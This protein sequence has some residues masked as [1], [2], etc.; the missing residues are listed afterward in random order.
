MSPR[1]AVGKN[2][3]NFFVTDRSRL[4]L[5]LSRAQDGQIVELVSRMRPR[6]RRLRPVRVDI[7]L[8][9]GHRGHR[10]VLQWLLEPLSPD[11]S[12]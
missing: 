9:S 6:D 2:L 4:V 3:P 1:G 11:P 10:V 8:L 12:D 5:E 7:S